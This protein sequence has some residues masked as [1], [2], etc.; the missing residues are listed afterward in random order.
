[1]LTLIR[2]YNDMCYLVHKYPPAATLKDCSGGA[3]AVEDHGHDMPRRA[4]A[5]P[6]LS[7]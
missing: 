5:D 4:Q 6:V 2:I 3:H 1:M 7:S